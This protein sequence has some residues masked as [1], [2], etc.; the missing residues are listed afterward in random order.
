MSVP[1]ES[2]GSEPSP[3]FRGFGRNI[4]PLRTVNRID[5]SPVWIHDTAAILSWSGFVGQVN[6]FHKADYNLRWA[7]GLTALIGIDPD[8]FAGCA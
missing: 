3:L 1:R 2:L 8:R 6:G 5:R 7:A 4:R